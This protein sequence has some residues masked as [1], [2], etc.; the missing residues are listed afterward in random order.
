M[1]FLN[2]TIQIEILP[3]I[4]LVLKNIHKNNTCEK[5]KC[6]KKVP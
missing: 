5:K 1:Q 4:L 6:I 3:E 2:T